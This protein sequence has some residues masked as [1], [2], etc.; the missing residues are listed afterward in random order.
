[1][2]VREVVIVAVAV[3]RVDCYQILAYLLPKTQFIQL[4]SVRVVRGTQLPPEEV[5]LT[6]HLMQSVLL[7]LVV[8]V[9]VQILEV[10]VLAQL[11]VLGV[12]ARQMVLYPLGVLV[13]LGKEMLAVRVLEAGTMV[14]VAV[15]VLG[16]LALVVQPLAAVMAVLGLRLLSLAPQ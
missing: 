11:V 4:L 10:A 5:A 7:L 9:A 2:A 12:V 3:V 14:A 6:R 13:H 8:A 16:L 1:V 15:A